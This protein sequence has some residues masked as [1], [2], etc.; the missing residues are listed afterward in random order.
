MHP[1]I[2]VFARLADGAAR[3]VRQI[4]GQSTL[5]SRTVHAI[6]YDEIHDEIVV[7]NQFAQAIL[8]FRGGANG[9]EPPI[10]VIHGPD[11]QLEAPDRLGADPVNSEIYVPESG[12]L[13]VYPR[14][15]NG[16]VAPS[17][18]LETTDGGMGG[19]VAIDARNDLIITAGSSA[20]KMFSR[21]VSGQVTPLRSISGPKSRA[22]IRGSKNIAV[23]PERGWIVVANQGEN[24]HPPIDYSEESFIGV[25]SIYDQ[26]D[27]PPR[28]TI[29]GPN[30]VL[31]QARGV[32]LDPKHKTV[33]VSD[34]YLNAALTFSFPELF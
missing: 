29:G 34:K 20:I 27:V 11:T 18:I 8:T 30:G 1:Q 32:V 2:A 14:L 23:H 33:I 7:P 16:N 22:A 3:P 24:S 10:R 17:R 5:L 4:H 6:A 21:A 28:W 13:L 15:A 26:G 9:E 25:W 12:R 31:R 19:A